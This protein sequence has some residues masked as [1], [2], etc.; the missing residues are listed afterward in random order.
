MATGRQRSQSLGPSSA[1]DIPT[2][3]TSSSD[4]VIASSLPQGSPPSNRVFDFFDSVSGLLTR[5][6]SSNGS[7]SDSSQPS[8]LLG[9]VLTPP[10]SVMSS[11]VP[12]PRLTLQELIHAGDAMRASGQL[13]PLPVSPGSAGSSRRDS[14]ST[15]T[16]SKSSDEKLG[17]VM[18]ASG[19]G[20]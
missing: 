8:P 14:L 10:G 12:S 11:P 7:S 19:V 13:K 18:S 20:F 2:H 1:M 15:P 9:T 17:W 5:Q 6:R 4:D 16:P 3:R